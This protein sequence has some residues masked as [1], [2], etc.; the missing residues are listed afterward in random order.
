MLARVLSKML[1]IYKLVD[2]KI[3]KIVTI[4]IKIDKYVIYN[5]CDINK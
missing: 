4:P 3:V 2:I 1:E 5:V